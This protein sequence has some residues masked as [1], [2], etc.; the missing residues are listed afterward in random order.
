MPL[1]IVT[2]VSVAVAP[3]YWGYRIRGNDW[4]NDRF[5]NTILEFTQRYNCILNAKADMQAAIDWMGNCAS[6]LTQVTSPSASA[7]AWADVEE[8]CRYR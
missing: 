4:D 7:E 1:M 6:K 5:Y 3:L 2:V 8:T